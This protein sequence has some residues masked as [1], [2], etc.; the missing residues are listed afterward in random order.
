MI[1]TTQFRII[2]LPVSHIETWRL[3]YTMSSRII[4]LFREAA[5]VL[6]STDRNLAY[7]L[8]F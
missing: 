1:S 4:N 5:R 8:H 6:C 2:F 3:K 7:S